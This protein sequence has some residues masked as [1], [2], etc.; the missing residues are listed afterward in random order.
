M[1]CEKCN[2]EM[3]VDNVIDGKFYFKCIKCGNEKIHTEKELNDY[4]E[5]KKKVTQN[6]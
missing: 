6:G 5:S 2:I 4:Y 3:R 1:M